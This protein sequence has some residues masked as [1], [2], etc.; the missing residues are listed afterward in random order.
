MALATYGGYMTWIPHYLHYVSTLKMPLNQH[1][2][3]DNCMHYTNTRELMQSTDQ[4]CTNKHKN[5]YHQ[6][7]TI[8]STFVHLW[9][10]NKARL[11]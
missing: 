4:G 6:H 5:F 7:Q 1:D 10:C 9:T 11:T 2:V 8:N 3:N